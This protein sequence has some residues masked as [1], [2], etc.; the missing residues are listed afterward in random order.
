MSVPISLGM[1]EGPAPVLA[2]RRPTR[3]LR[4]GDVGVGSESPVSV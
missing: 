2:P 1:P 4:V 3:Q